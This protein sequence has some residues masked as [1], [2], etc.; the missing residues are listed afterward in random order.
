MAGFLY[1]TQ[2]CSPS[3]SLM[4]VPP[5]W[6]TITYTMTVL[7]LSLAY[8]QYHSIGLLMFEG[9]SN[10]D[11]WEHSDG[12]W[13][14]SE[15]AVLY[16]TIFHSIRLLLFEGSSNYYPWEHSDGRREMSEGVLLPGRK[17]T[18]AT[19]RPGIL[20]GKR[21]NGEM[22]PLPRRILLQRLGFMLLLLTT[23]MCNRLV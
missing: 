15:G 1:A 11:A 18:S 9:S 13:E 22:R 20:P 6:A 2:S 3:T 12:W 16:V 14:I 23:G 4:Y 21:R 5:T 10:N 8:Y 19:M 7:S 17:H